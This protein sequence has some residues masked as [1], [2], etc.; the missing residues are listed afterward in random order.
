MSD[1]KKTS[2][3]RWAAVF[4]LPL[5]WVLWF[6]VSIVFWIIWL[7]QT[8]WDPIVI[9]AGAPDSLLNTIRGLINWIL[10]IC[11]LVWIP[12]TIIWIVKVAAGWTWLT[13]TSISYGRKKAKETIRSR[14]WILVIW[15]LWAL[16]LSMRSQ[17]YTM[18]NESLIE[19]KIQETYGDEDGVVQ[20][21][22]WIELYRSMQRLDSANQVII[23]WKQV[24][25]YI[26]QIVY[27]FLSALFMLCMTTWA[28]RLVYG[29]GMTFSTFFE[30][31][32]WW[33]IVKYLSARVLFY[34]AIGI[35]LLPLGI[36]V[37]YAWYDAY[38][39]ASIEAF[40]WPW[41]ILSVS[42]LWIAGLIRMTY[43]SIRFKFFDVPVLLGTHWPI[44][45]IKHSR[46]ITRNKRWPVFW[47]QIMQG[48]IQL[49]WVLALGIGLFWTIP[50]AY[51]ADVKAY[52]ILNWEDINSSGD[53]EAIVINGDRVEVNQ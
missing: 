5:I 15:L 41:F 11:A 7:V 16:G 19:Q 1:T 44:D 46:K 42:I 31:F 4:C 14:V 23:P 51:I 36:F 26:S 9:Q 53:E 34:C 48:F 25:Y 21:N 47:L 38:V 45:A 52:K 20:E 12:L 22:E 29:T 3:W 10:G 28:I 2:N 39:W 17:Q 50:T 27:T 35:W 8:W 32:R 13:G 37:L 33:I 18:V 30:K 6:I 40:S 24:P 49:P 43:A